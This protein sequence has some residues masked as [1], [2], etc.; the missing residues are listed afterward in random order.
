[1]KKMYKYVFPERVD[2]LENNRIR[3]T[4]PEYFNDPFD[5]YLSFKK[6]IA[7]EDFDEKI[8]PENA[9]EQIITS[10]NENFSKGNIKYSFEQ[11]LKL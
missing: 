9:Y 11:L 8:K 5:M 3:F 6:L 7:K 10:F 1:M 4:Q 2:I